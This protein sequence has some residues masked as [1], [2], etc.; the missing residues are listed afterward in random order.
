[1]TVEAA[2]GKEESSAATVRRVIVAVPAV[3]IAGGAVAA[4]YDL[5]FG[6]FASAFVLGWSQLV[7]P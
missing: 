7:G 5:R 2:V 1:L 4:G 6:L 3:A